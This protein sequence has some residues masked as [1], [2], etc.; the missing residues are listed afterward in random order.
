MIEIEIK[1]VYLVTPDDDHLFTLEVESIDGVRYTMC[2]TEDIP[3]P[4]VFEE[5]N[6][7]SF[8]KD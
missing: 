3:L 8:K 6:K 7:V 1:K 4:V 2:A 5:T